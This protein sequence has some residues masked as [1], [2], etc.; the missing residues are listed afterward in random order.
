MYRILSLAFGLLLL[1]QTGCSVVQSIAQSAAKDRLLAEIDAAE[2]RW[3]AQDITD[4]RIVVRSAS[5]WHSQ[6]DTITVQDGIVT[7][8]SASCGA[9]L[10]ESDNT[11]EVESID[12]Q[13]HTVEGLFDEAR[14]LVN[15][16]ASG[17][18]FAY[19]LG[20][21]SFEFDPVYGY[22][23]RVASSPPGVY[24]ADWAWIVEGFEVLS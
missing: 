20:G 10:L 17:E 11:C 3:Q 2:A 16:A 21:L 7:E 4:Y 23:N 18:S 13:T 12:P 24:D 15:R 1:A 9:S 14:E 19:Q 6:T 5:A 8:H 22:P